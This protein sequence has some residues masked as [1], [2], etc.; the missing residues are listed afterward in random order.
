M[1]IHWT[2]CLKFRAQLREFGIK[3]L[4]S[5]LR[6]TPERYTDAATGRRVAIG[7]HGNTLV[8]IPYDIHEDAVIPVTAS[9]I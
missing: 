7:K 5:I 1:D 8:A 9:M 2:S 4:A 3:T 6:N